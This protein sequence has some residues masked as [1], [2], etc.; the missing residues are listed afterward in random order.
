MLR[1]V[2]D[3]AQYP[4]LTFLARFLLPAGFFFFRPNHI[5]DPPLLVST[6]L[7]SMRFLGLFARLTPT[8]LVSFFLFALLNFHFRVFVSLSLAPQS[9]FPPLF[10]PARR[11]PRSFFQGIAFFLTPMGRDSVGPPSPV[12]LPL[13]L[14]FSTSRIGVPICHLFPFPVYLTAGHSFFLH[15]ACACWAG[16]CVSVSSVFLYSFS[17]RPEPGLTQGSRNLPVVLLYK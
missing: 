12:A 5:L 14:S 15:C 4:L 8:S 1:L 3:P 16:P 10:F 17:P 2:F 11:R 13:S 6:L 9:F 7:P